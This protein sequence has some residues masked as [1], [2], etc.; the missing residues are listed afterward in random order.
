MKIGVLTEIING[1][2]GARA[3]LEIAAQ[4]SRLGHDITVYAYDFW[5]DESMCTFLQKRKVQLVTLPKPKWGKYFVI[6]KLYRELKIDNPQVLYFSGT[7]PF[8][9]AAWLTGTPIVRMYQGTQFDAYLEY[10]LPEQPFSLYTKLINFAANI[11]IYLIDLMS[12][13]LSTGVVAISRYAAEEGESLYH[14]KVHQ[15]IYHGISQLKSS[16]IK[17]QKNKVVHILSVSRITPYKGFHL[18]IKALKQMKTHSNF[19]LTIAG[20]QQKS[21]YVTYLQKLAGGWLKIVSDPSDNVLAQLYEKSDIY[22]TA[23]RYLYFGLPVGE[24]ARF[25]KPAVS[26]NYAAATEV[27]KHGQTGYIAQNAEELV[28]YLEM[29]TRDSKLRKRMGELA[30]RWVKQ[31]TWEQAGRAWEKILLTYAHS[32]P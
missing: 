19:I 6:P 7:P 29:L 16:R 25:G 14:R 4:L 10:F 26:L 13:R 31:F 20:S 27:I 9:I 30:R 32:K 18:I 11:F 21:H 12:F 28:K 15:V 3:P 22:A 23:D 24:A 2:S 1:H 17:H 5:R 8:F